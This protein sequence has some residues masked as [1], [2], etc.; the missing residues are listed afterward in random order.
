MNEYFFCVPSLVRRR[1]H[2]IDQ[3]P[4]RLAPPLSG[5]Y[6]TC[7][8][9]ACSAQCSHTPCSCR[10]EVV[11]PSN[12]PFTVTPSSGVLRE[13]AS[14]SIRLQ[15][16]RQ[17]EASSASLVRVNAKVYFCQTNDVCLFEQVSFEIPFAATVGEESGTVTLQHA[18]SA[19]APSVAL[20]AL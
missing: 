19:A 13:G 1:S 15:F 18:V 9:T 6:C 5:A 20:P 2:E 10:Y 3:L 4:S 14:P 8:S 7:C 16:R 11:L 12:T 17:G